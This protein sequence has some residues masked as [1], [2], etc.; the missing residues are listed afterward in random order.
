M[1]R[2][3]NLPKQHIEA[4]Y[5][6]AFQ[7]FFYGP[8]Y[9]YAVLRSVYTC[10]GLMSDVYPL[11]NSLQDHSKSDQPYIDTTAHIGKAPELGARRE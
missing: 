10:V 4:L 9:H 2:K 7:V 6:K 1:D 5:F 8:I 3:R 11:W